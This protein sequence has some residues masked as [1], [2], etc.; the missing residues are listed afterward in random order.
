MKCNCNQDFFFLYNE[1]DSILFQQQERGENTLY[2]AGNGKKG[3][4][5]TKGGLGIKHQRNREAFCQSQNP[6]SHGIPLDP[7]SGRHVQREANQGSLLSPT[8]SMCYYC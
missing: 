1:H 6:S 2:L 4:E 7:M 5:T 8:I 3:G